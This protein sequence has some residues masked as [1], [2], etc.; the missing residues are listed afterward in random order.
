[1]QFNIIRS[2]RKTL[3]L[4][5]TRELEII[6]RAPQRLAKREIERFVENHRNWIDNALQKQK[7]RG[8]AHP[9]PDEA[10]QA[11]LFNQAK[12]ILPQRVTYFSQLMGLAPTG[13]KIT[14]AR[15]RFGSCSPKNSL[16]FSWRLMQYPQDAIDYVV[17]HEL[18][19]IV[20]KNHS[21]A[22][23]KLI[24]A[25]IPDYRERRAMLRR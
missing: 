12:T 17:V 21:A 22:F 5:V 18:A 2:H 10:E 19:H 4:E 3:A 9:E 6:V 8:T 15:R 16:C 7:E 25:Y 14:S 13:V 20:H 11:Y 24:E 23:Y 1:M